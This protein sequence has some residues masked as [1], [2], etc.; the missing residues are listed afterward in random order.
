MKLLCVWSVVVWF[1]FSWFRLVVESV[2]V[3]VEDSGARALCHPL[4]VVVNG[5]AAVLLRKLGHEGHTSRD[6]D[7]IRKS[8]APPFVR[9]AAACCDGSVDGNGRTADERTRPTDVAEE[10]RHGVAPAAL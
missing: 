8:V 5:L 3:T 2:D 7:K 10:T 9:C 1:D 4:F 6:A